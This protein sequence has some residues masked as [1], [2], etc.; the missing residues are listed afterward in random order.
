MGKKTTYYC[1]LCETE[2][3]ANIWTIDLC[4]EVHDW[5]SWTEVEIE[6][7]EVCEECHNR[8]RVEL[9]KLSNK[10]IHGVD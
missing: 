1:D 6:P 5:G 9:L 4:R 10:L 2:I 3:S 7:Y 8:Y